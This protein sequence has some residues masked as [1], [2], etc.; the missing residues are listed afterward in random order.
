[1]RTL[2]LINSTL[3]CSCLFLLCSNTLTAQLKA[4]FSAP[5]T[6]GCAP[7]IF[8]FNDESTGNPTSWRWDLGNGTISFLQN[9]AATYFNPG[10]YTV[11][12]VVRNG[13][14]AD[15]TV[16]VNY[17][18][19]YALPVVNFAASD[20]TGCFPLR[21]Q[22]TDISAAGDG[23]IASRE[24]DLGDGTISTDANPQH[25]YKAAGNYTVSLR[26]RNSFGCSQTFT[27]NE[28]IKL[29]DGVK[30][31]FEFTMPNSCKPPTAV[32]FT[33]SSTGTG[34]LNYQ[35]NFGDGATSALLNPVHTFTTPGTY[36]V[37]LV[38]RNNNG[39]VDSVVK[40]NIINIGA[41]KADFSVPATICADQPFALI[42]NSTPAPTGA[43]W[44]FGD[45]S[46]A[47]DISPLKIYALP[48]N[49]TIKLVSDFGLCKDSVS[50][51]VTVLAIIAADF[52]ADDS[53]SCQAPFTV[54]FTAQNSGAATYKWLFGDGQTA[55]TS[56]TSHT[57]MATGEYDV[58]LITI[59]AA[60]CTDTVVKKKY[61]AISK[62]KVFLMNLPLEGCLPYAFKPS[63]SANSVDSITG[64]VWHF[65]NGATSAEP[66]PLYTYT[67]SGTYTVKLVFTTAGGCT[68]SVSL[69]NAIRVG[70]KPAAN[71]SATPRDVCAF[72]PVSF[73][74][75]TSN[76][77]THRWLYSFGDGTVSTEQNPIHIYQDTG[78]FNIKLF[79]WNNGCKDTLIRFNYVH[80]Q[81]PVARFEVN[82]VDCASKLT[83]RFTDKSLGAT[84]WSWTF[85]DGSSS[86][87]KNPV[88]NYAT[89]GSYIVKLT[90]KNATCEHTVSKQVLVISEKADFTISDTMTCKFKPV[91]LTAI[92]S[93]ASNLSAYTWQVTKDNRS[94]DNPTGRTTSFSFPEAGYYNIQLIITD[95]YG[96]KDS[97]YKPMLVH[98]YGPTADFRV[99]NSTICTNG[100]VQFADFSKTDGI[101]AI[102]KWLWTYGDGASADLTG[103][104]YQHT[105]TRSGSYPVALKVTDEMGC[106]HTLTVPNAVT[107]SRPVV[108]FS[109]PDSL[110]CNNK[111]VRFTNT[112]SGNDPVY[113]WSFGDGQITAAANPTHAYAAEG[114]YTIKLLATDRY[115]CADSLTKLVY[116]HIRDPKARFNMSDSMATCP[117]LLV[118]FTNQSQNYTSMEWNFGD[119]SKSTLA[120]PSHLYTYPGIY[121]ARV[122]IT[123]NGG[124]IDSMV[125]IIT[126]K[127]PQG[128]FTYDAVTGCVPTR[129]RFTAQASKDISFVWDYNDGGVDETDGNNTSHNF[130]AM[131]AYLPKMILID[132]LGCRVPILGIDTIKIFGAESS[133]SADKQLLCDSGLVQFTNTIQANDLVTAYKWSFG[134]GATST[135]KEPAHNYVMA[136]TYET[137]LVVITQHG[138]T[139]T[140]RLT[141]PLKIVQSPL[142]AIVGDTSS[143]VPAI[144]Q[145]KGSLL[146]PDT[147]A[148][149]WNW[150]FGNGATAQGQ[151]PDSI[152][153]SNAGAYNTRLIVTNFSGCSD[154]VVRIVNAWPIPKV[155]AGQDQMICRDRSVALSGSG[156]TQYTWFPA[157][158]LNCTSCSTPLASPLKDITYT[159]TGKTVYGCSATDSVRLQVKQPFLLQTGPG[160]TLCKSESYQ[161]L[162]TG[163]E[164]YSWSPALS[165]DNS[166]SDKPKVRPD[167]S[168]IY[169]VIGRDKLGC[170]AD[171]GFVPVVVYNYPVI[172]AGEDKTIQVGGGA[173]INAIVSRDVTGIRWTPATGL[174]C[175]TCATPVA[176]PK[177][178]LTYT[179]E[180]VNPG[181]CISR[182][183]VSVFVFCN[184]ANVF[185]PNTFSPNGDG[186]NDV[187]YPRGKGVYLVQ[188]FRI[189][190]R[191]GDLVYEKMNIQ[192]N[193]IAKGWKGT[194]NGQAAPQDVYIY[195]MDIICENNVL[196]NYKGNVALI[197]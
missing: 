140:A 82:S 33:N 13:A 135:Q 139:D 80:I 73:K 76:I 63:F 27:R 90:V 2:S 51:K 8:K 1:M 59:N 28:Y 190:N 26:I 58:T 168:V 62:P 71:F 182:D 171:T 109:S 141:L 180:A 193:D 96:C 25:I 50:K 31:S 20:T 105:Y 107:I 24:W 108:G 120:H 81:P 117:P 77:T 37:K 164:E 150:Q 74:D 38:I 197:R 165:M 87:D 149:Q 49:Y 153:Y 148:V 93:D 39:C 23:I 142:A 98:I 44:S 10:T 130:T 119:G 166:H 110:S 64:F 75:L 144:L 46:Y 179:L 101:H 188:S 159:V 15:S 95:I 147:S 6:A 94:F 112:T 178:T 36:S 146:R 162:A 118:N 151:T 16:K 155:D 113:A 132:P 172:E 43:S 160:D 54:H 11:K 40:A 30:A 129:I 91:T 123:S 100:T 29:N 4:G 189:F 121:R 88:H 187:F 66:A 57:Y 72:Q 89:P 47:S 173:P 191:W 32:H 92:N 126:V 157:T 19:V 138:C 61:I 102:T 127:G 195:S 99:I 65:G 55:N 86:T 163:A 169:R 41:V 12:L 181:G 116:I 133:F 7:Q 125:K 85:G 176:S 175:A 134:D 192:A 42:N 143:C 186:N 184:N 35:W 68:D 97:L 156:A 115:G 106:S 83:R 69:L 167:T 124:C 5:S 45:G 137:K 196:M 103:G 131:G 136:G 170:F 145:L 161:L 70:R 21:V 185:V 174:S 22:F 128:T 177:Q 56:S 48:G 79:V 17:I 194:H 3:F 84:S 114:D 78:Y 18:T 60:G 14:Q 34:T 9:P 183:R 67:D 122:I 52:K 158:G 104:P 152:R 53:T 154:T 111:L